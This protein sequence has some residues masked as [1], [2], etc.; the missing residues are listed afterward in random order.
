MRI[1]H[2]RTGAVIDLRLFSWR[3]QDH[4][5][6]LR[7]LR[8]APLL[9]VAFD[10]LV[11]AGKTVVRDQVLPDCHGVTASAQPQ[12]NGF[13]EGLAGARRWIA[14]RVFCSRAS[15]LHAKLVGHPYS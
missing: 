1:S 13:L 7:Q 11:A 10:A 3:G 4:G 15:Q 12:V 8:A 14:T 2:H 9:D 5:G 6:S